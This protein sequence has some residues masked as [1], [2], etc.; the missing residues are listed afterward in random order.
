M[1][2]TS[3]FP[4]KNLGCMGDG[5]AIMTND[6]TIARKLQ[7]IANHGMSKRYHHDVVGLNSRLDGCK[8]PSCGSNSSISCTYLHARQAAAA[9]YDA[10]LKDIPGLQIPVRD[11]AA[12][13]FSSVHPQGGC[14]ST[15]I[16]GNSLEITWNSHG[17]L[18]SSSRT[19]TNRFL[20]LQFQYGCFPRL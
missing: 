7:Q 4:S 13:T 18:L 2:T 6:E 3:F 12:P 19:P 11:D 10:L 5:G 15:R 1:G 8:R 14:E 9:R 20:S 17:D 16:S